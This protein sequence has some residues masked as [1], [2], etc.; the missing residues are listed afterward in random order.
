MHAFD[1]RIAGVRIRILASRPICFPDSILPFLEKAS[2]TPDVSVEV[3]FGCI[4]PAKQENTR[5]FHVTHSADG[6]DIIRI[7]SAA[8]GT[9]Y[10]LY[11]PGRLA[12]SVC[13]NGNWLLYLPL[14][15]LMRPFRRVILH[16]SAVIYDKK[17]YVFAAPSGVGKSTQADIW[18]REY[19]AE[20]INGDKVILSI[21]ENGIT[22]HGGPA[23]GSSGIYKNICA[24][25]AAIVL[26]EQAP[27]NRIEPADAGGGYFALY[28]GLVK[29]YDDPDFNRFLLPEIEA[30]LRNVP[31]LRLRCR[32][33]RGAAECVLNWMRENTIR[34]TAP[35]EMP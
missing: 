13:R 23:A 3:F 22:A 14:E 21:E 15:R 20:I 25:A 19:H 4:P 1:L 12:D 26:L 17:A 30:I 27:E 5:H 34:D 7:E 33:D 24:P 35:S 10:Q 31:V 32:P 9:W 6:E 18:N 8:A 16:A 29:S 2:G 28:S 11:I